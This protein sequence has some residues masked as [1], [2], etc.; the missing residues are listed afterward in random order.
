MNQIT[1]YEL[2]PL[3]RQGFVAMDK[4]KFWW[5]YDEEPS[6]RTRSW[7]NNGYI[8]YDLSLMFNI[9]PFDGDWTDSLMECGK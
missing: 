1:I 5:W 2:L 7:G 8:F 3:M 6:Q 9:A 4:D